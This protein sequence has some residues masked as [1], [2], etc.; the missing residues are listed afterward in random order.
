MRMQERRQK[1]KSD[2][3]LQHDVM[4]E[5]EWDP[6]VDHAD[7]GVVVIDGV[8]TLNGNVKSYAEKLAAERASRRVAGVSAIAE[9]LQVRY[10]ADARPNDHE[11]AKRI[12]DIFAWNVNVPEKSIH[13]KVE[14]GWV[15]LTGNVEWKYQ[16]QEA[17]KTAAKVAGVVGVSNAIGITSQASVSDVR[18][19]IEDAFRRQADLDAASVTVQAHGSTVTLGG[20][21]RA[22]HERQVA[23]RAAWAAPGVTEVIDRIAIS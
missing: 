6:S 2:S 16:S 19:R 23:E 11:V 9:E 14:S 7:I 3:R 1:V 5:L 18:K 4:D 12:L 13:V 22:W 21:V 8:V 17:S 20:K 15:T 10:A